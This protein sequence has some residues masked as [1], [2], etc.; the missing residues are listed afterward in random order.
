M[1]GIQKARAA[2][3]TRASSPFVAFPDYVSILLLNNGS[4]TDLCFQVFIHICD[5][6]IHCL[7]TGYVILKLCGD[8]LICFRILRSYNQVLGTVL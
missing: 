2:N 1:A 5:R 3:V 7:V 6:L 8:D 4:R